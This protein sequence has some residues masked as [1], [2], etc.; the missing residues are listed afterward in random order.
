MMDFL[1]FFQC[2]SCADFADTILACLPD[3]VIVSIAV[4]CLR[5]RPFDVVHTHLVYRSFRCVRMS[6]CDVAGAWKQF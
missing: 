1:D 3:V 2:S 4:C 5:W 6:K